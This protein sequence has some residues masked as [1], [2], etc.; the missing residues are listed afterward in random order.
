MAGLG[1]LSMTR[2]KAEQLFDECVQRG[3]AERDQRSKF[4]Q[5]VI[6]AADQARSD[7]EKIFAEQFNRASDRLRLATRDD[8]ARL[9][10]KLDALSLQMEHLHQHHH[11][12]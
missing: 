4:V 2:E 10:A 11:Q 5:D 7:V 1:A 9:E 8:I 3:H 6:D 12:E